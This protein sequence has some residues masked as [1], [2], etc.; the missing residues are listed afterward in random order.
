M[1]GEGDQKG[2]AGWISYLLAVSET[3][4]LDLDTE[5]SGKV[6]EGSDISLSLC[7]IEKID[8]KGGT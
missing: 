8:K 2:R 4:I 1:G 6:R 3:K 7:G 5:G